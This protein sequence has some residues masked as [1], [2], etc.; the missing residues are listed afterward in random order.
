MRLRLATWNVNSVRLRAEQVARFVAESGA[1]VLA[2]LEDLGHEVVFA[3]SGQEGLQALEH[4]PAVELVI[5]DEVMP[6]MSGSQLAQA[7]RALRPDIALI[8]A[9]GYADQ[10]DSP[11]FSAPRLSKPFTQQELKSRIAAVLDGGGAA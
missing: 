5:T 9:T 10:A 4:N 6:R 7:V 11:V 2:M 3:S 1:D 8:L